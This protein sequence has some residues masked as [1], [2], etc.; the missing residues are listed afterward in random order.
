MILIVKLDLSRPQFIE[1]VSFINR[2]VAQVVARHV[3]DV[4][5]AGSSP[6]APTI[7]FQMAYY[8]LKSYTSAITAWIV[9]DIGNNLFYTGIVG[10]LFPL[11]ITR[12]MGGSEAT[13]GNVIATAM[14]LAFFA[15]PILG[16]I[17]DRYGLKMPLLIGFSLLT[18]LG[19]FFFR[20]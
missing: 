17:S 11:W 1:L 8:K 15:S 6:V 10:L 14:I 9:Y 16:A 12:S 2:G 20:S 3:R 13:L 18:T 4:E 19:L 5:V 7:T